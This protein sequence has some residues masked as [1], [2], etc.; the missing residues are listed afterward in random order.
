MPSLYVVD[1]ACRALIPIVGPE[2]MS[3]VDLIYE[4]NTHKNISIKEIN[5]LA[6]KEKQITEKLT[7]ANTRDLSWFDPRDLHPVLKP[8]A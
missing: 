3:S 2:M 7:I 8:P 4:V 1:W 6:N 5:V